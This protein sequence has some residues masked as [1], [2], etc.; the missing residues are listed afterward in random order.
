MHLGSHI[1]AQLIEHIPRRTLDTCV[2]TYKGDRYTK[3][4]TSRDH[5]LTMLFGQ[6][7]YRESLR[8]VITCLAVHAPKLYHMG[9]SCVPTLPSVARVNER[10]DYRI[11][12]DLVLKLSAI[13]QR[14]YVGTSG[15]PDDLDAS[16]FAVDASSIDVCLSLFP[17]LPFVST[18]GA[19][20]L[21][22]GLS[23]QGSIPAFF[24]LTSGKIHETKFMDSLV[25]ERGSFYIFDRGY[26]DYARLRRLHEAGAYFVIRAKVNTRFVRKYSRTVDAGITC[27][28]EGMID[29]PAYPGV[30][31]RVKYTDDTEHTYVLLTNNLD[32]PATHVTHLYKQRWQIELFFKW[33]KQ[34]LKVKSFWGYSNNAAY[35]QIC[36]ALCTY[37]LVAIV[38]KR[39]RIQ[40][41]LYEMLQ[42]LSLSLFDKSDLTELFSKKTVD[43][44]MMSTELTA[45][46]FDF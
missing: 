25:Y 45:Q 39:L 10:R 16:C 32:I 30:L 28:Q 21:H 44:K 38:K 24:D 35:T 9:F 14:L 41:N 3:H 19:L 46:L 8:D 33:I 36:I 27:D 37:L 26:I 7:A 18:K 1:F 17:K 23:L 34:H 5:F 43:V 12:R 6:L 40:Q 31:R 20:K 22:L 42:I 2:G 29:N 4:L 11:W 13:A 15:V